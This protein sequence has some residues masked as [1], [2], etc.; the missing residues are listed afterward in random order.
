MVGKQ[1]HAADRN[2]RRSCLERGAAVLEG[3]GS[4]RGNERNLEPFSQNRDHVQI[5]SRHGAVTVDRAKN[6]LAAM[7]ILHAHCPFYGIEIGRPVTAVGMHPTHVWRHLLIV[8]RNRHAL[9]A[10]A[11]GGFSYELDRKS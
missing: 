6:D 11:L 8:D 10:K 1:E 7:G 2:R 9:V 3:T 4:T 5:E